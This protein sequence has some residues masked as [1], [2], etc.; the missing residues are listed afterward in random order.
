[1][2]HLW[3][4]I[5]LAAPFVYG[6]PITAGFG[7]GLL[8]CAALLAAVVYALSLMVRPGRANIPRVVSVLIAGICLLDA[9]FIA[10]AGQPLL[11]LPAAL[12]FPLTLLFQRSIPGT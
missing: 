9:L 2:G 3:P 6:L 4:L 8:V 10:G 11:A 1:V 7:I 12:G 5:F